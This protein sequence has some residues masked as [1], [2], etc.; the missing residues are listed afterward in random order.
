MEI[1]D[2]VEETY[3]S[4]SANKVRSV[5]TM[6]GIVIGIASVIAMV[7]IGQ[8]AQGNI[9]AS[10]QS[11]GSNLVI[12]TPG[13]QRGIGMQ[14]S[15]GRGSSQTLT[16]ADA[17]AIRT[18]VTMAKAVAPELARRYQIKAKG[19][20]TNTNVIG[21]TP[22]Y[23][24][25]RN[26]EVEQGVFLSEQDITSLGR[27]AVLGPTTRN[28]LFG[29]DSS[30]IGQMITINSI[31]FKIIGITKAKGGT[32]FTNPDDVMYIPL[33]TAQRFLAGDTYVSTVSVEAADQQAMASVQQQITDLLLQRHHLSSA[34]AADF[35]V[36]NQADIV[37][38]ASSVTNTFT[39][40]LASIA[41]ISLL[42]GGIG[43]MNMML[44]TVTERTREIGLR[45]AIGAQREDITYQFLMEA[46]SL[47]F[48]GG[49]M[50]VLLGW[51]IAWAATT[52]AGLT[53]TISLSS[54]LLAFGVSAGIGIVFGFYP[55]YRAA[56]LNPIEALRYE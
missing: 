54:V 45:K 41:G 40:L 8:G 49:M 17:D 56:R 42:V 14:V 32:G 1:L 29:V 15:A 6:L 55:A 21:T 18:T 10:I 5:L 16:Q 36:L 4:L 19:T 20:N 37:A 48:I 34:A 53:T 39:A 43:I 30:P 7:A 11:A 33:S 26:I 24:G 46:V 13:A 50:G 47:T 52:F 23:P 22:S 28:D 25:V 35:S 12:V 38:S 3:I 2:L 31:Q 27:V 9:Q 51:G 44:T